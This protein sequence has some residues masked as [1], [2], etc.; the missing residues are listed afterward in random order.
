MIVACAE[1]VPSSGMSR[2]TGARDAHDS[3]FSLIPA[4][5]LCIPIPVLEELR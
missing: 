3:N 4:D 2:S 5:L 1:R